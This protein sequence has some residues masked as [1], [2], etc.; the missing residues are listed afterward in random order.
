[1]RS[2]WILTQNNPMLITRSS[3]RQFSLGPVAL[4]CI[5]SASVGAVAQSS[6]G[7]PLGGLE[8]LKNFETRRDS[9]SDPNWQNG[10]SDSRAIKPGGTLTLAELEGP[11]KIVHIWC[12]VAQRD[13]AYS[14]KLT[15]RIYWDDEKNPSVECPLGDFFGIGFGVDK[16]F[17]SLPIRVSSEGR[18]RNCYWPMPF[19]KKARITVTNE[20]YQRCD[21]FY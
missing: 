19:R 21:N 2:N 17:T 7:D 3:L 5:I 11:G 18:G 8:I 6:L 20:S 12:T 9:S 16:S 15:L 14:E 1:L 4:A 10:N 13:P